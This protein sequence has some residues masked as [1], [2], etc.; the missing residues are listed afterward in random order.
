MS[1]MKRMQVVF[2]RI[3][4]ASIREDGAVNENISAGTFMAAVGFPSMKRASVADAGKAT[5]Y[6][7]VDDFVRKNTMTYGAELHG[8]FHF[9]VEPPLD[10]SGAAGWSA[11]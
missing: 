5:W 7:N 9:V 10:L 4:D 8:D 2:I 3:T 1:Y 11:S 6:A